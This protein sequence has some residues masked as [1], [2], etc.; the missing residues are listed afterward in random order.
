MQPFRNAIP[1]LLL[2]APSFLRADATIRYKTEMDSPVAVPALPATSLIY[3]KG[4]KGVTVS[5]DMTTIADFAKQEITLVDTVRKKYATI[6]ASEYGDR[7]SQAV[8]QVAGTGQTAA[9]AEIFNSMKV[10]CES[11][12]S[13][14]SE[15]IQG[16]QAEEREQTC[17]LAIE[18]PESLKQASTAVTGAGVKFVTHIWFAAPAERARVPA[19]WQLSGFEFW[20]KYFANPMEAMGKFMPGGMAAMLADMRKDQSAILRLNMEAYM[21]MPSI[22]GGAAAAGLPTITP[23]S[24]MIKMTQ[25][26]VEL[27]TSPLDDS[28][29]RVPDDCAA[30][31]FGDVFNGMMQA[32]MQAPKAPVVQVK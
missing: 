14:R 22:P 12:R 18:L 6:P 16:V 24:P 11:K 32:H 9:A 25:E 5:G 7:I 3:M 29:F 19:L 8:A 15:V 31:P 26:I 20:S 1:L 13:G 30:E 10:T 27:S 4:N 2:I 21:D 17:S 28:L 23:G